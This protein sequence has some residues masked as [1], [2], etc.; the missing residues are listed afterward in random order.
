MPSRCSDDYRRVEPTHRC[1]FSSNTKTKTAF[2][3]SWGF[4]FFFT[5]H[6]TEIFAHD[7]QFS[8]WKRKM[9]G[10]TQLSIS[11]NCLT[12]TGIYDQ[13]QRRLDQV[14][15]S[16]S[17]CSFIISKNSSQVV[18]RR[19]GD[20]LTTRKPAALLQLH[21]AFADDCV[22]GAVVRYANTHLTGWD[23]VKCD[24]CCVHCRREDIQMYRPGFD[25]WDLTEDITCRKQRNERLI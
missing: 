15:L 3:I 20:K 9:A 6:T 8:N 7:R 2:W 22:P 16:V 12:L 4:F 17:K 13:T 11:N 1:D 14:F 23:A 21:F 19:A 5:H 10:N 18:S 24:I 25:R